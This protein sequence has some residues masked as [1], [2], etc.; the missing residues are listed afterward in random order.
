MWGT[1]REVFGTKNDRELKR[2]VPLVE[3]INQLEAEIA[4]L[5]DAALRAKTGE[6]KERLEKGETLDDLLPEAFA[7]VRE[8]VEAHARDAPLRRPADRRHR[9]A[10]GQDRRDEDRR[11]QDPRRHPAALP[12]RARRQGRPRRH[13]E[14]LPRPPRRRVDGRRSTASSA[15]R[16]ACIVHDLPTTQRRKPPTTPT[17]PTART[18]SS[19]STTCATT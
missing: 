17:S 10:R 15:S 14:R 3:R 4:A 11:G 6:F 9:A 7:A 2:I 19:A 1:V 12:E 5:S 18:T 13:G 8:A 16:S